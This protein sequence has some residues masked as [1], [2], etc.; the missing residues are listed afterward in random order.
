MADWK[1]AVFT[2]EEDETAGHLY[3]FAPAERHPGP[4]KTQR[5]V[6][7]IIDIADDGTLA[8]IELIDRMPPLPRKEPE[9]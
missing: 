5:R 6:E 8:G 1:R 2:H 4:Y 7:A 3:Y 9:R